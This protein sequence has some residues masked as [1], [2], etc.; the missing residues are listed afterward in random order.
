[1]PIKKKIILEADAGPAIQEV[2]KLKKGVT[3]TSKAAVGTK[4][5]FGKMKAGVQGVS[6]AFKALGIGAIIALFQKLKQMFM[7]NIEVARHF[8]RASAKMSAALDVIRDRAEALIRNLLALKNPLKAIRDAFKGAGEEIRKETKA[9]EAYTRALQEV[10]DEERA[11]TVIRAEAN[12]IIAQSRLL[13]EDETK[14]REERLVALKAA[15]AEEQRV[16]ALELETQEKKVNALQAIIDLGKSSEDDMI[17]L[18]NERAKFIELQ[19][20]SILKQKRVVTEI[21]TFEREIETERK[22]VAAVEA[23]RKA[24]ELKQKE[25]EAAEAQKKLDKEKADADKKAE[26]LRIQKEK[27][28]EILRV[29]GMSQQELELDQARIKHEKLLALAEKYGMD[30]TLINEKYSKQIVEINKKYAKEEEKVEKLTQ[31]NKEQILRGAL[32]S[33]SGLVDKDSKKGKK[34]AKALAI[35]DT[36]SAANKALAQ[37][38][39][40]GAVAAAG[41]V[42][43]GIAN[44]KAIT[45]QRLPGDDDGGGDDVDV[46]LPTATGMGALTPN[47]EAI[48]QPTLGGSQPVQAFVVESNISDAQALQEEL[49]IQATL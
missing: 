14:T 20:A 47:M 29:S 3:D 16:A 33:I 17:E 48:D 4:G 40:F 44:V 5:A 36:F 39:I 19:T 8:E 23:K 45:A 37:G 6:L 12:K 15:V 30:T 11:M 46:Q 21:V 31:E 35:I 10:R 1:M 28:L 43:A 18:E 34:V 13:A 9:V 32:G 2:D 27:E 7:G 25:K 42:A 22:R 49:D 41:V 38:G 24:D 26:L